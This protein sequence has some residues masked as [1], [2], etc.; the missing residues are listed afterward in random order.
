MNIKEYR[1]RH[2][3]TQAEFAELV[4]VTPAAVSRWESGNRTPPEM[5]EKLVELMN[6]DKENE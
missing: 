3:L 1:E 5:L 6:G 2:G 4:G